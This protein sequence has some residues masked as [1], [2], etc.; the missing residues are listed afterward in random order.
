MSGPGPIDASSHPPPLP[1]RRWAIGKAIGVS[2]ALLA[3]ATWLILRPSA[4]ETL[5]PRCTLY[6]YTGLYCPGC[7]GTRAVDALLHGHF[8]AALRF[9]PVT[10]LALPLIGLMWARWIY[11]LATNRPGSTW[12]IRLSKRTV[13]GIAIFLTLYMIARNLPFAWLDFIRPPS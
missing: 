3:G 12:S 8:L 2:V 9:N 11:K 6:Q 1:G 4:L 7:G 10:T 5:L 13:Y